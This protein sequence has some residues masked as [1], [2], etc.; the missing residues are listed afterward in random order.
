MPDKF[1]AMT[2]AQRGLPEREGPRKRV[3]VIGAGMAGLA[4]AYELLKQGHEPVVLEARQRV[5]GRVYTLREP[6]AGGLHAE[7]GAMR[8][9]SAHKLTLYYC[10]C[11][12]LDLIPFTMGNP[13]CYYYLQGKRLTEG[14]CSANPSLL[15]FEL[16]TPEKGRTVDDL[17]QSTIQGFVDL[18]DRDGDAGWGQIV[19]QYD[20]YSTL[21][22][23]Q[24]KGWSEGAIELFGLLQNQEA[25]MNYSFV[26]MLREEVGHYYRDLYQIAGGSDRLP[27]AFYQQ[28][29]ARI[30]FGA[31][32]HTIEQD[33]SGVT[34]HY[35]NAAGSFQER[36]DYMIVTVPFSVLRHVEVNPPFS[37][38]KQKAIRE[39][40][41]DA[42]SKIFLQCHRRF[43]E[44]D[45]GILGGATITDL[46]IRNMYY[47]EH[48]RETGRGVLLASYTWSEDAERWGSL[49]H[50]DRIEQAVENVALIHPQIRSEFEVGTSI[51]WHEDPFAGGA[52]ALFEPEQ[53]T[54]LY[55]DIIAP[56]GRIHIAGEHASLE[57][58]WIQ[59]ALDSGLRAAWEVN[60]A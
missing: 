11:F 46:A 57:H 41:Y 53:Q 12:G 18:I 23:L 28:L 47:P 8:I 15:P 50:E 22:F 42:S 51:M 38:A 26:E 5:G 16:S 20:Q 24:T 14:D 13:K 43:W 34:A 49:S 52:F 7:A 4:A 39:L 10:Q 56:E 58:A 17:W 55:R 37:H 2:V 19:A 31:I 48:G 36:G 40:H 9:P 33:A 6:F 25:L 60:E 44:E 35:R 3:L 29:G 1:D 27:H 45:E 30:R 21:E 54:R 59:G 32:V